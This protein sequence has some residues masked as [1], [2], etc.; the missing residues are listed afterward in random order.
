[1]NWESS[2]LHAT[3]D[4]TDSQRVT[5]SYLLPVASSMGVWRLI[6]S[7]VF[8]AQ[9]HSRIRSWR[10]T[11]LRARCTDAPISNFSYCLLESRTPV[12]ARFG[13]GVA[14]P[15]LHPQSKLVAP[16]RTRKS[17]CFLFMCI[18]SQWSMNTT[19]AKVLCSDSWESCLTPENLDLS[20]SGFIFW[21]ISQSLIGG[22]QVHT[23]QLSSQ[24][25]KT[26]PERGT[27]WKNTILQHPP[28]KNTK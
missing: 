28:K 9:Q 5:C 7:V 23:H 14:L 22:L 17:W 3:C 12:S 10:V 19:S 24:C 18:I 15:E 6:V 26:Y 27:A 20:G 13:Q 11:L 21:Q 8:R 4:P 1:M 25:P 2:W 16:S